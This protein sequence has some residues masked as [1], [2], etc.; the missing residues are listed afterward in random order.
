MTVGQM[1]YYIGIIHKDEGSDYGISFP[2][3]PGCVSAG[4]D[5]VELATMGEEALRGHIALM[6]DEGEAVP[7]PTVS[8]D[9][10]SWRGPPRGRSAPLENHETL[11]VRGMRLG[12]LPDGQ[13]LP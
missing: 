1:R 9:R 11:P 12:H 2:D 4:S 8:P 3:F 6:A 7:E 5:L 10:G 13:S